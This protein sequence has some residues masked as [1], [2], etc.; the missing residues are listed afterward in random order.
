MCDHLTLSNKLNS[1][2]LSFISSVETTFEDFIT[3]FTLQDSFTFCS[4]NDVSE[5]NMTTGYD[6]SIGGKYF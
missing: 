3:Y 4:P 6:Y 1:V 5:I 2:R